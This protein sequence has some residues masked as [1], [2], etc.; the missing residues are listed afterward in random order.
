MDF[1]V[2]V[3]S[4]FSIIGEI[5]LSAVE[6]RDI[7]L[8]VALEEFVDVLVRVDQLD[9]IGFSIVHWLGVVVLGVDNETFHFKRHTGRGR[10]GN[11]EFL[12]VCLAL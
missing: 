12:F 1:V 5:S 6:E 9:L 7:D 11:I 4:D 3:V 2:F 10:K 8:L